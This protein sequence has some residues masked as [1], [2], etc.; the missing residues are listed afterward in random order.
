MNRALELAKIAF[1]KGEV[2]VGAVVIS[3]DGEIIGEGYNL[4]E[5]SRNPLTHAEIIAIN[6]AS[7]QLNSWRLLDCSIYI[8]LEPCAMCYGAIVNSRVGKIIFGAYDKKAGVCGSLINLAEVPFNHMPEVEG[9]FM[10]EEC[11]ALLSDFFRALRESKKANQ[12]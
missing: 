9:G 2:P 4:R 8:T 5:S 11:S 10:Q 12:A 1:D 6:N 7:E 3:P